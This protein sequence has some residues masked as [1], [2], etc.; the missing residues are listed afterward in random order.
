MSPRSAR[1]TLAH[2]PAP[3]RS[4]AHARTCQTVELSGWEDVEVTFELVHD[5][6]GLGPDSEDSFWGFLS[7]RGWTYLLDEGYQPISW[8]EL[9]TSFDLRMFRNDVYRSMGGFARKYGVLERGSA[10]EDK[11]FF[12][13]RWGYLFWYN[14]HG[15]SDEEDDKLWRDERH[16]RMWNIMQRTLDTIVH[17]EFDVYRYKPSSGN[18]NGDPVH[19]VQ[20]GEL[21][22][23]D[24]AQQIEFAVEVVQPCYRALSWALQDLC[25]SYASDPRAFGSL[26]ALFPGTTVLPG[27]VL[28]APPP[29]WSGKGSHT[30]EMDFKK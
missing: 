19:G 25:E 11:L 15:P 24:I 29:E 22:R 28:T 12:E 14:R 8:R 20:E 6:D 4:H 18:G 9:P 13:F 16:Y 5:F 1:L 21:P 10:L 17:D 3:A 30:A 27:R 23:F 7:G 26:T 2:T